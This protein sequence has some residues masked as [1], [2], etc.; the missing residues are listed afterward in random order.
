MPKEVVFDMDYMQQENFAGF[1]RS[2]WA[3][4][5]D[6]I[7]EAFGQCPEHDH[8]HDIVV[9]LDTYVD[10]TFHWKKDELVA[11]GILP[12]SNDHPW[13]G[14]VHHTFDTSHSAHNC[15]RLFED[16]VFR[17]S[18]P[19]CVALFA[20]SEHLATQLRQALDDLESEGVLT[21]GQSPRVHALTHPTENVPP[22]R[23]FTMARFVAN[24]KRKLVQVGAWLRNPYAI[25]DIAL[26]P[27]NFPIQKAALKG[28]AMGQY[29]PPQYFGGFLVALEDAA[30][31]YMTEGD[32]SSAKKP[33]STI[34]AKRRYTRGMLSSIER[35]HGS[36]VQI[37]ELS[38]EGYDELLSE[39]GV[40]LNLVDAS[41]VNT[42]IECIVRN[43]P[44][45]VNRLPAN[46]EALGKDYPGF[47]DSF[48]CAEEAASDWG[49]YDQAHNYLAT[50]L[51]KDRFS[52]GHF[53]QDLRAKT[54]CTVETHMKK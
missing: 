3:Y 12:Y 7:R 49:R 45:F 18:L 42:V 17:Q 44:V 19:G 35:K 32:T 50:N 14:F 40:F 22:T 9:R 26:R 21:E 15:T 16:P 1:H 11:E 51:E 20:L 46:E 29:F 39:N 38:N 28:R 36:V 5:V 25:Y 34:S 4:V 47:Y 8:D 52:L 2:G 23:R 30:M 48:E 53:L 10:R 31:D 54:T 33:G 24:P 37:A 6:G 41:A 13:T 43:T 27:M